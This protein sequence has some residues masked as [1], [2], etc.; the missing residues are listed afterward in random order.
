MP[1]FF[2]SSAPKKP[3]PV[4]AGIDDPFNFPASRMRYK[5]HSTLRTSSP[6]S[7]SAT[8]SGYGSIDSSDNDTP[9]SP[10]SAPARHK[11]RLQRDSKGHW[12]T[13]SYEYQ[14]EDNDASAERTPILT[15]GPKAPDNDHAWKPNL[16][17][18]FT[19]IVDESKP[20]KE[21]WFAKRVYGRALRQKE[22]S[23]GLTQLQRD[24]APVLRRAPL[25]PEADLSLHHHHHHKSPGS[26]GGS[27]SNGGVLRPVYGG[28]KQSTLLHPSAPPSF[29]FPPKSTIRLVSASDSSEV[30]PRGRGRKPSTLLH[31]SPPPKDDPPPAHGLRSPRHRSPTPMAIP[32]HS[33]GQPAPTP[34][35]IHLNRRSVLHSCFSD[36][37]DDEAEAKAEAESESE[38]RDGGDVEVDVDESESEGECE[39]DSDRLSVA[40]I[41]TAAGARNGMILARTA[42]VA[43]AQRV[44]VVNGSSS[45]NI[46]S[47]GNGSG[48]GSGSSGSER[49]PLW[50]KRCSDLIPRCPEPIPR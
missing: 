16:K 25:S 28:R 26:G 46:S 5:S 40:S 19:L 30:A 34:L 23:E 9:L 18:T 3:T 4:F 7:S 31:P 39:G 13:H 44:C 33:E 2:T 12:R 45:T 24:M 11:R 20:K 27:S 50:Q 10:K 35:R 21:K 29:P 42:V 15:P 8:D 38:G 41:E 48:S 36:S 43:Q 49:K 17:H 14:S 47:A 6:D 1:S 22:R 32:E 37:E